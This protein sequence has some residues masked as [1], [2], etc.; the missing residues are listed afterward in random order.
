MSIEKVRK[1]I[2][3][4]LEK[5][6]KALVGETRDFSLECPPELF[7]GDLSS[8]VAMILAKDLGKSPMEIAK[9][10][11]EGLKIDGVKEVRVAS[12]GFI[13]FHFNG[14]LI[15]KEIEKISKK[16]NNTYKNQD[17]LIEHSSPNLF[18]PFHIGHLMNNTIGESFVRLPKPEE[19]R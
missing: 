6:V 19:V 9:G 12:P 10:F 16:K 13:N 11:A 8:N 18:K 17:I 3:K 14:D 2:R 1:E 5:E 7:F 4:N 15:Y